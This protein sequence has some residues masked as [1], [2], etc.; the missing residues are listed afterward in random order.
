MARNSP[1]G[2]ERTVVVL[3]REAR[4][5]ERVPSGVKPQ[6][7]GP[8]IGSIAK[9]TRAGGRLGFVHRASN[10]YAYLREPGSV[11]DVWE[12]PLAEVGPPDAEEAARAEILDLGVIPYR[13]FPK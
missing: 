9:D 11:D 13:D 5:R 12:C 6:L 4:Q 7:H 10:L 3:R 8:S 2:S 1:K